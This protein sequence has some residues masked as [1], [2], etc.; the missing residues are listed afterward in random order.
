MRLIRVVSEGEAKRVR[1]SIKLSPNKQIEI[2]VAEDKE[3][4]QIIINYVT[5]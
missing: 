5:Q 3:F 1:N 4:K 2:F